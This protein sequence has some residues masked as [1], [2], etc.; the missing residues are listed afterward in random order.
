LG[1][2][3]VGIPLPKNGVDIGIGEE[4]AGRKVDSRKPSKTGFKDTNS[5]ETT[6]RPTE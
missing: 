3:L 1:K 4:I 5:V 2:R 6:Y